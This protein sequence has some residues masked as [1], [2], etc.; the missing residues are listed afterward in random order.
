MPDEPHMYGGKVV[1]WCAL[2]LLYLRQF[3]RLAA[4]WSDRVTLQVIVF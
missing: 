1:L 3:L 4:V 2:N